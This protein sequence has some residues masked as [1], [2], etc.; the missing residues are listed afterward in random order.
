MSGTSYPIWR[1]QLAATA[2]VAFC[3]GTTAI[4][5]SARPSL[6]DSFRLGSGGG[7]LCRVQVKSHDAAI[8][9]IFDRAW[10]I[11]CRDAAKPIGKLY[12]LRDPA[13]ALAKLESARAADTLCQTAA[14]TTLPE[15]GEA[16]VAECH[17]RAAPISYHVTTVQ[18]GKVTYLTE[19][20]AAYDS[21]LQ[22]ALRTIIA[23]R[24]LPGKITVATSGSDN[25]TAFARVQAGTLDLDQALA[26]GY[27]RNNS[28][29]YAEAAAFFDTLQA[30]ALE[31][32]VAINAGQSGEYQI[33]RALQLS[34][35]G[36]FA[37]ADSLFTQAESQPTVDRV[38]TR[39]RRNFQVIHLINQGQYEEAA[40]RL[41]QPVVENPRDSV[42]SPNAIE[43]GAAVA[44]E[45]NAGTP[46]GQRLGAT[47]SSALTPQERADFLDA[48]ALQLQATLL[49]L[50]GHPREASPLF[51]RAYSDVLRVREGRVLSVIR[52]RAQ[53]LAEAGLAVEDSGNIGAGEAKMREA[54]ALLETRY[55]QTVS[56]NG[57]RARLAAYLARHGQ[58]SAAMTLY[59]Q[60]ITTAVA[61]HEPTTGLGH[62]LGPYFELLVKRSAA[63]PEAIDELFLAS[64]TQLRPGVADTQATLGR[65]LSAGN[66]DAARLFRQAQTLD[67]DIEVSRIELANI[68]ALT[69]PS[70][71]QQRAAA[72][73]RT[74]L[75]ELMAQQTATQAQLG[76]YPQFR[77]IAL[78]VIPAKDIRALLKPDEAYVKM[79]VVG[80]QA[81]AVLLTSAASAAWHVALDDAALADL[82]SAL[83]DTISV[84][85]NGQQQTY[86]FDLDR[87]HRLYTAL[88]GPVAD[89]VQAVH[90][91][92]FEP[93]GALLKL[94]INLLVTDQASVDAYAARTADPAADQFN[95]TGVAWLGRGRAISTI[96]SAGGFRDARNAPP[97]HAVKQYIGF[98]QNAPLTPAIRA[99]LPP[100]S[101]CDWPLAAWGHPIAAT[102]I[103]KA[104]QA[105]GPSADSLLG[106][107]FTDR[108]V[109]G[110]SSLNHYRILHFA[111]HG[112]VTPPGPQCHANPALLTSFE[113]AKSDGLL[114]FKEIYGL[115]LDADV[116][117]L[118]ACDTASAAGLTATREA[119]LTSGGTNALDGLVRAFIG[120]GSRTIL[121]THWPAPED[122]H[123][124][125][126]LIDGTF[127]APAGT[128]VADALLA[129]QTRLMNDPIT[130]HPYYWSGFAVVG[131]G[132]KPLLPVR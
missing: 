11:V 125:E 76:N 62:L 60:V 42:Q 21:A 53:I 98:G 67:R 82:V 31:S 8:G 129:A 93:D 34:N 118:S 89:K 22:L 26:E 73:L 46:V 52:L 107:E 13:T 78:N 44:A 39:L 72:A 103:T 50:Q 80:E 57:A 105:I 27:R 68:A 124:T 9:S 90:H 132:T 121:A 51:E 88:F 20:L 40:K 94:P 6:Q 85:E 28:G 126:K 19:G 41:A 54:L 33:N 56:V 106:A 70:P 66:Q 18:H 29:N 79:T 120:A 59:Q 38:Q 37:E 127:R 102:E 65:E 81:Y 108:A 71:D 101:A 25:S 4:A 75:A 14:L 24:Q 49:R 109:V 69:K 7:T 5:Q 55:P 87:A 86:P 48:Q 122:F 35:L 128:S 114:S 100:R 97:S 74:D 110:M 111:T 16:N 32:G 84:Q 92:L 45:I 99:A 36:S 12:A 95:F 63:Q 104:Q 30:R 43:I 58:D 119:G 1:V 10:T 64:Q 117:I 17:L 116:V 83:R 96:V 47:E 91:I 3:C 112:L 130:S 131:D 61:N 77:A 23:D 15:V 113:D 115:K 123:A 2:I